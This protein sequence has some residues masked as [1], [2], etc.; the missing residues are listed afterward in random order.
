M[1]GFDRQTSRRHHTVPKFYLRGFADRDTLLTVPLP[2]ERRYRQSVNSAAVE[3]DFYA[4][5]GHE[6][7]D[8]VLERA[9]ADVEAPAAAI[10]SRIESGTW[11][12]SPEERQ[13]CGFFI[14]LQSTRTQ[15]RRRTANSIEAQ[16]ARLQIG[17]GGRTRFKE[18]LQQADAD[19]TD[20]TADRLWSEAVRP[21]GPPIEI[22]GAAFAEQ[23]LTTATQ[24]L[25]YILG[26][27]WTLVR[28]D[29][30]SLITSDHPISLVA[31]ADAS[32]WQGVGY[33]TAAAILMP[34]TRKL[35]LVMG[36][37]MAFAD[38]VS[39]DRVADG[40]IDT[41]LR[42]G[43]TQME[44]LFN[45]HTVGFASKWVFLHPDDERFL[46]VELP[47]PSPVSMQMGS[48]EWDFDGDPF[49][50]HHTCVARIDRAVANAASR[51]RADRWPCSEHRVPN[52][53]CTASRRSTR[54]AT[55]HGVRVAPS[56]SHSPQRASRA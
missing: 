49:G 33:A 46:P 31:A 14:A 1:T 52:R 28:F 24:L 54:R 41:E 4:L 11:P 20:E 56:C 45:D 9:L 16:V 12:I 23:M 35:G 26:R 18:Q 27:P 39:I 37:P 3:T 32:P 17:L 21:E 43:T 38:H 51:R 2:G 29:R 53:A 30:R 48:Q 50:A 40:E 6:D 19:I 25:P 13:A 22:T 8:D 42:V 44:R 5:P 10:I 36:D 34:L 55:E 47:E 7:G 15:T